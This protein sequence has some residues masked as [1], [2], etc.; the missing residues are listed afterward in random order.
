MS[1]LF[2]KYHG[3][4]NDFILIDNRDKSFPLSN[5]LIAE[6][7]NRHFGIGADGLILIGLHDVYDFEMRYFNSDGNESTMCGNGG[8]CAVLFAASLSLIENRTLFLAADGEHEA[9]ILSQ[10]DGQALIRLHMSDVHIHKKSGNDY[11]IYTGSPHFIKLVQDVEKINV[12]QEGKKIRYLDDFQPDGTNV[13]FLQ[14]DDNHLYVRTYER[15]VEDETLSC[16]TGV[17]ASAIAAAIM[18]GRDEA[19]YEIHTRGGKLGVSFSASGELFQHIWL[20][21]PA[22][23]VFQGVYPLDLPS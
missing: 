22:R 13:D 10:K 3:T 7:C 15:G 18:S 23:R 2:N 20:E 19:N 5:S 6:M 9:E 14:L 12:V 1:I 21:G 11:Y 4:G 17:T 16:G 8:R